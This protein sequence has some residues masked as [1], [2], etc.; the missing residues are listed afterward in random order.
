MRQQYHLRVLSIFT[1]WVLCSS[2]ARCADTRD[3]ARADVRAASQVHLDALD[4][5]DLAAARNL[6]APDAEYRDASGISHPPRQ[7]LARHF[8][9]APTDSI[10]KAESRSSIDII[11]PGVAIEDGHLPGGGAFR[12]VWVSREGHWKIASLRESSDTAVVDDDQL[13]A[14]DWLLGEWIGVTENGLMLISA[15]R[16]DDGHFILREFVERNRDGVVASGSQRIGWDAAAGK[17][18][19]WTFDSQGASGTG[20]WQQDGNLWVVK[21][22]NVLQDGTRAATTHIYTRRDDDRFLW[23]SLGTKVAGEDVS[24]RA[25]QFARAREE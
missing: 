11:A 1:A 6:W 5:G 19:C 3:Q 9:S 16:C 22:S 10:R 14:L 13:A 15:R 4:R 21:T 18:R 20:T 23:E 17:L 7:L 12:A 8:P 24:P 25:I 2:D